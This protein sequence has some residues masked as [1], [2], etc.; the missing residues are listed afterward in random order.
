MIRKSTWLH[1]RFPFSFFLLPVYL[2]ALSLSPEPAFWP[3]LGVF[4][5]LHLLVYPAS[6]GYNSYFDRDEQSIGLL[7]K[8]PPVQKQLYDVSIALDLAAIVL[9]LFISFAFAA[10][11]LIYG[12]VSKAYSHPAV[13]LKKYPVGGWLTAG[14]FQGFFTFIACWL[15]I[16]GGDLV[17]LLQPAVLLPAALCSLLLWGSYPM[18]QVYQH[19]EDARRGDRTLSLMLGVRGTFHFTALMFLVANGGFLYFYLDCCGLPPALAFQ[20]FLLPVL[21]FFVIWYLKVRRDRSR[22]DYRH[23]MQLNALSSLCM[24]AFFLLFLFVWGPAA[25]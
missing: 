18:T 7:R 15:G 13:R 25:M 10:M 2:F 16:N 4:F 9:A 21:L 17:G 6:N 8:P 1:L 23:T 12:L 24:N 20:L 19:E 5:I 11:I 3:A 14:F 22:A